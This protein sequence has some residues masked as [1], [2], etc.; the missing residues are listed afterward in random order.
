MKGI[1]VRHV[2][3]KTNFFLLLPVDYINRGT[4]RTR[5]DR[6]HL[7]H[8]E[9]KYSISMHYVTGEKV[10][11][12]R[13]GGKKP[14]SIR[15]D[16]TNNKNKIDQPQKECGIYRPC[17]ALH[18]RIA[19]PFIRAGYNIR[20]I[21]RKQ[22]KECTFV[23]NSEH[24]ANPFSPEVRDTGRS[25]IYRKPLKRETQRGDKRE[26]S[27]ATKAVIPFFSFAFSHSQALNSRNG[28][29]QWPQ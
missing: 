16:Q 12:S 18:R 25:R 24:F 10:E 28:P 19:P 13:I 15:L 21:K 26:R 6:K 8:K 1:K 29:T 5:F 2:V 9:Q 7:K 17:T 14:T 22:A 11:K 23:A 4:S 3:A 27:H 20:K